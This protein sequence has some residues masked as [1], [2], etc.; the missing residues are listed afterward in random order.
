[1]LK[2]TLNFI[3]FLIIVCSQLLIL[4]FMLFFRSFFEEKGRSVAIEEKEEKDLK[5]SM[6]REVVKK[7]FE[8]ATKLQREDF[9]NLID[10]KTQG[11]L[12]LHASEIEPSQK[13]FANKIRKMVNDSKIYK[14]NQS[15]YRK[16][17]EGSKVMLEKKRA[18]RELV[19]EIIKKCSDLRDKPLG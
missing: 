1:M 9:E 13:K 6:I 15:E 8:V 10:E 7:V 2:S 4:G 3:D 14:L 12:F 18:L 17:P 16:R 5:K 11:L 19:D